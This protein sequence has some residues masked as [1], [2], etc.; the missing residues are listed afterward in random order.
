[1]SC[2]IDGNGNTTFR[3][4]VSD[5]KSF[6][7]IASKKQ[8]KTSSNPRCFGKKRKKIKCLLLPFSRGCRRRNLFSLAANCQHADNKSAWATIDLRSR[9]RPDGQ[10]AWCPARP[11]NVDDGLEDIRW[12]NGLGGESLPAASWALPPN[13]KKTHFWHPSGIEEFRHLFPAHQPPIVVNIF[14]WVFLKSI[15]AQ[16]LPH[17]HVC[18]FSKVLDLLLLIIALAASGAEKLWRSSLKFGICKWSFAFNDRAHS[19]RGWKILAEFFESRYC[20][21]IFF[22]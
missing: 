2:E 18:G 1:M 17:N 5:S 11:T 20:Y 16:D 6:E 13:P 14:G 3:E 9:H 15:F 19:E 10:S 21:V 12:I 7:T 22:F 4:A 8:P